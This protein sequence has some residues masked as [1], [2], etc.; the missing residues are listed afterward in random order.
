MAMT[1]VLSN[2]RRLEKL[3]IAN[4]PLL[5]TAA[6]VLGVVGTAVATHKAAVKSR[7]TLLMADAELVRM[8]AL[9]GEDEAPVFSN[10]E[11]VKLV[12]TNYI[13]P[14]LIG[15]ATIAAIVMSNRIS[16]KRAAAMS[17]AYTLSAKASA[18][19]RE[20]IMEKLG[21]K[22]EQKVQDELAQERVN[23]NPPNEVI[24]V[25]GGKVLCRDAFSG[26]YFRTTADALRKAENDLNF[27]INHNQSA[28]LTDFYNLLGLEPTD[29]SDNIGW[30]FDQLMKLEISAV[31]ADDKEP[32]L[33]FR[34]LPHPLPDF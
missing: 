33:E 4:S 18:E 21:I 20:K 27:K 16:V 10:M 14:V 8:A 25:A 24:V 7:D 1:S 22:E 17:A 34:F 3:T 15:S 23:K 9:K 2:L 31:V 19:Y 32:C 30:N 28:S 6:G 29:I 13:P 12:W 5:L 26:Q 11:I